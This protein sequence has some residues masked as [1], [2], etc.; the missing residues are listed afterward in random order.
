MGEKKD[1]NKIECFTTRFQ[2][3][4]PNLTIKQFLVEELKLVTNI[5]I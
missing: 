3:K 4:K 2:K 1:Q 5:H